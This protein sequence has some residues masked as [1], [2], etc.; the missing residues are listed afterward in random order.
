L[1]E[2]LLTAC[3]CPRRRVE[4]SFSRNSVI[5]WCVPITSRAASVI[6]W[7]IFSVESALLI[8]T[9]AAASF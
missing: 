7:S 2:K 6:V 4:P 3:V 9:E 5:A 8:A 1:S